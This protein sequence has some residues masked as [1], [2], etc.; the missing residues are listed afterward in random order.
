MRFSCFLRL[1]LRYLFL[2]TASLLHGIIYLVCALVIYVSHDLPPVPAIDDS[3]ALRAAFGVEGAFE[4]VPYSSIPEHVVHAFLAADDVRYFEEGH[5][6]PGCLYWIHAHFKSGTAFYCGVSYSD[7]LS[8]ALLWTENRGH[9]NR[10][11]RCALDC[12]LRLY[13]SKSDIL[14]LYLNT[15]YLGKRCFGIQAAARLYFCKTLE[16]LTP[17]EGACLAALSRA[18]SRLNPFTHPDALLHRRNWLLDR[19]A[20]GGFLSVP[21][22]EAAKA[23]P[24]RE[25]ICDSIDTGIY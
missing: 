18:P 16:E 8:R 5:S 19:M 25:I 23:V 6:Q 11:R 10:L 17:S 13:L 24:M 9:L 20:A 3:G 4:P 15:V 12:K 21:E 22:A 14:G 7:Q 1:S 2:L